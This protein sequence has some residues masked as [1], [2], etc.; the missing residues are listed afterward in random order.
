MVESPSSLLI[1]RCMVS[2]W[3]TSLLFSFDFFFLDFAI[4]K[5]AGGYLAAA[6]HAGRISVATEIHVHVLLC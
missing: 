5:N 3:D 1:S 4:T 2:W 6:L